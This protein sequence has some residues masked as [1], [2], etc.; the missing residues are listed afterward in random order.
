MKPA[1][2]RDIRVYVDSRG[3][4]PYENWIEG[5]RD[6]RIRAIISVRLDRLS[7]GNPGQHKSLGGGLFE[8]KIDLGPG[9]RVYYS[10]MGEFVVLLLCGGDKGS[11][12]KD[13][14][15]ARFYLEDYRRRMI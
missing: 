11:Q 6:S 1:K 5:L 14:S 9:F 10:E 3:R 15:L 4:S 8:L 13:V 7:Q 2:E 12:S